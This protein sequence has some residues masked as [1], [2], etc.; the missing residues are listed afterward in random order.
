MEVWSHVENHASEQRTTLYEKWIKALERKLKQKTDDYD[1][2]QQR[3]IRLNRQVK[4]AQ[5]D[6]VRKQTE[7]DDANGKLAKAEKK[8]SEAE[9]KWSEAAA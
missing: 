9:N 3:A 7:V 4:E 2:Q 6:L 5:N 8:R 1:A